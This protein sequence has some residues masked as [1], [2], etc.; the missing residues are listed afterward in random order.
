MS[1]GGYLPDDKVVCTTQIC[2]CWSWQGQRWD[3]HKGC[4]I[5]ISACIYCGDVREE[6][7]HY[8]V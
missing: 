4:L 5:A 8:S 6:E 7:V 1:V 2:H 3:F